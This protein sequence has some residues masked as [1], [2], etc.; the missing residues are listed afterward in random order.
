MTINI[1]SGIKIRTSRFGLL[2]NTRTFISP[3]NGVTQRLELAGA[4]WMASYSLAPMNRTQFAEIQAFLLELRGRANTFYGYD[5][6]AK[7][8]RGSAGSTPG[9]PLVNG[10]SQTGTSLIIDGAPG[11]AASYLLA[12]DYFSV[13]DELKMITQTIPTDTSGDATLIFE[14]PLRESPA[15]NAPITLSTASAIMHLTADDMA[16]WDANEN[17]IYNISFSGAEAID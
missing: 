8:A 2:S 6:D 1:P 7:T 10:G 14:P 17:S 13:N 11:G 5:P 16:V 15:D 12:G 9:T 4:R 3:F